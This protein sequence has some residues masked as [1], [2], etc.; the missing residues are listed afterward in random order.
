M[1]I[2]ELLED[3]DN[4]LVPLDGRSYDI[5]AYAGQLRQARNILLDS[6]PAPTVARMSDDDVTATLLD[7]M[8]LVP[9]AASY[10]DGIDD[11]V[12]FLVPAEIL[13]RCRVLQR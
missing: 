4:G 3:K 13:K 8:D 10:K 2:N 12:I 7:C 5:A 1:N 6:L 11:E 9:V